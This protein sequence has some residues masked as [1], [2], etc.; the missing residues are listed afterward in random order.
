MNCQDAQNLIHGYLDG[1]LDLVKSLEVEQHLQDCP[2][3]SRSYRNQQALHASIQASAGALYYRP[4]AS[5]RKRIQSSVKQ[6][7]QAAAPRVLPWR[8]LGLAASL[9]AVL[10][11]V[12][13]VTRSFS[14]LPADDRLF[15]EVIASHVRALMPSHLTDVASSDQHAVKPW[16]NGKL[17]FSPAVVD[18]VDQGFPLIGGRLDYLD[19]R[20][21]A[22]LV[23]K[24]Q[25]HV[26]NLYVWPSTETA[27]ANPQTESLQGFHVIHWDQSGMNYWV[28]S[29]LNE[30]ELAEFVRLVQTQA[31]P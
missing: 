18:L 31:A 5:L 7:N 10:F 2:A 14:S 15:D 27:G 24:R 25:Q 17:D 1:E 12:W 22:A 29:D 19:N 3:C 26:I 13:G 20:P 8:W 6:A 21:V 11:V 4:P 30:S 9:A 16:F 28:V 23:Y